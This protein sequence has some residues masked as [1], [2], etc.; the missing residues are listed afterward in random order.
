MTNRF[1]DLRRS[2]RT[3]SPFGPRFHAWL[4]RML[5]KYMDKRTSQLMLNFHYS[6]MSAHDRQVFDRLT[7]LWLRLYAPR[8]DV[9][10]AMV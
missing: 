4:A 10:P 1:F 2:F 6:A 3:F 8:H 9:A 7:D 5:P